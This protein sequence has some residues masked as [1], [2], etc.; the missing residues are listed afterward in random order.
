[1]V[2]YLRSANSKLSAPI[3]AQSYAQALHEQLE[4]DEFIESA[5]ACAAFFTL[6]RSANSTSGLDEIYRR[7]FKGSNAPIEVNEHNW[8]KHPK[9]ASTKDLKQYFLEILKNRGI[10]DQE[11]WIAESER[12]L[13]YNELKTICR[14]VL[15][16][17]GHDRIAD[18]EKPGLTIAGTKGTCTL[19]KLD[20]WVA[21]DHKSVEHIAPQNPPEGHEWDPEIYEK[22]LVHQVGNLMLL[23]LDLNRLGDNKNWAVKYL[24][25]SHV[26]EP[27]IT[28]LEELRCAAE[29]KGIVLS[30][31]A[32]KTLSEA[33]HNCAIK[34]VLCLGEDCVWN[35]ALIRNRT[36][37]IKEIAWEKLFSWLQP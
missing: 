31:K 21:K 3:L 6:W 20:R 26:S 29:K 4:F 35:A 7:Y 30:K 22:N 34:A 25:Y 17:S 14:F 33:E 19:L 18:E 8:K 24:Y 12:F 2:Q 23:P 16:I 5:K 15:F 1:M 10:A 37:Q 9:P 36:K 11:A 13:L 27:S 28:K 32:I